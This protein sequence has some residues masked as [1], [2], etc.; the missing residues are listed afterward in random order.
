LLGLASILIVEDEP[1][2]ALELKASVEEAGGQVVGP[3]GTAEAALEL[4]EREVVA[5]AI[6]DIQLGDGT[7]MPPVSA[8]I[9]L[10]SQWSS[11]AA[12]IFHWTCDTNAQTQSITKSQWLRS[13]SSAKYQS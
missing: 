11:K 9:N 7:V 12:S 6:L 10:E 1:F 2:T 13:C 8:L 3:V 4:L 5:A